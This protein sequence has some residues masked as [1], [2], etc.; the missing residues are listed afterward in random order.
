MTGKADVVG[1]GTA[2]VD[3]VGVVEKY[4]G[5]DSQVELQTLS[6]QTGGNVA[7]APYRG[8]AAAYTSDR[9]TMLSSSAAL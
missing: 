1:V 4:P 9:L 5:P 7:T 2:V 6:K 8:L 3:Y